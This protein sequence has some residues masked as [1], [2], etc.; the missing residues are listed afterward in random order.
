MECA[1]FM[2]H[3]QTTITK[4]IP[5]KPTLQKCRVEGTEGPGTYKHGFSEKNDT[6]IVP[7]LERS[8]GTGRPYFTGLLNKD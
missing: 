3:S 1:L 2:V 5:P 6:Y 8:P 7:D 4:T